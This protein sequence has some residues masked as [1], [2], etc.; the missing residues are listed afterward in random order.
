MI[1]GYGYTGS[2]GYIIP[3]CLMTG[4]IILRLDVKR[5]EASALN[6]EKKVAR[7]IGWVNVSLGILLFVGT[8]V[9]KKLS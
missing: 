2:L 6:K 3:L 5:Y 1:G 8:W 9:I 4:L 7:F